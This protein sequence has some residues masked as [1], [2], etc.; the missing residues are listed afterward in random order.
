[1]QTLKSLKYKFITTHNFQNFEIQH[2]MNINKDNYE[3]YFLDYFEGNLTPAEIDELLVFIEQHPEIKSEFEGF[4]MFSISPDNS[5]VFKDKHSL[6]KNGTVALASISSEN[7]D[8]FLISELEGTLSDHEAK[9][10][11]GFIASNPGFEKDRRLYLHTRLKADMSVNYPKKEHLMHSA[12]PFGNITETNYEEFMVEELEGSLSQQNKHNLEQFLL[13]NPQLSNEHKL[14]GLTKLQPDTSIVFKDKASLKHSIVPLRRIVMYSLSAAASIALLFGV[15]FIWQ[16]NSQPE[17]LANNTIIN[18]ITPKNSNA[19][20]TTVPERNTVSKSD[21]LAHLSIKANNKIKSGSSINPKSPSP[22]FSSKAGI[23]R[24]NTIVPTLNALACKEVIS[25]DFVKPE[26]MFIRASQMHRNEYME[27]YYN[28]RLAE[29]IQYAQLNEKDNNPEKT[30]FN[31]LTAKIA[32][33]IN[34]REKNQPEENTNLSIWTFAE[35]GVKTY[36]N[37]SHDNVKLD[38]ERDEQG[39][40]IA[41]NLV[42]DNL[43]LQREVKK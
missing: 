11:S 30:I 3:A 43:D 9:L 7:V 16:N 14:F 18:K 21:P 28:V 36:N 15:Y 41:Y 5:I 32:N 19:P 12:I 31:S 17:N 42:G 6:K 25:H 23:S 4:E 13:L 20:S 33:L 38:L 39:K 34:P 22:D 27:L 40:V 26:F 29:Q 8:E 1:M 37:M 24:N 2:P 10:L 35:L